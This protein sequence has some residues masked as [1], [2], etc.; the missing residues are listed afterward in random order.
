M[1]HATLETRMRALEHYRETRALPETWTVIRV[2]GR[3]FSRMTAEHFE[4]PFDR[5]FHEAM[6]SVARALFTELRGIYAY[7]ESDEIS[8]LLP[9]EWSQFGGRV[10]KIVSVAAGIA[11][12]VFTR[13]AEVLAHFDARMWLGPTDGSVLDYFRWRQA[14][15]LRCSL[16]GWCYWTLR[17]AGV[18]ARA[19]TARLSG[20]SFEAKRDLLAEHGVDLE[21]LEGWQRQG[22]G[23]YEETYLK[24]GFNPKLGQAVEALRRRLRVE[25]ELPT[26]SDYSLWLGDLLAG[27]ST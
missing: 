16:N 23:V 24:Q 4:K 12:A 2:D 1:K 27:R 15:A 19:A 11:S 5:R 10:E 13:E 9:R 26:G 17:Q 21:A 7:T 20:A 8:L 3:S 25:Q 14:D 22:V 6:L 18:A